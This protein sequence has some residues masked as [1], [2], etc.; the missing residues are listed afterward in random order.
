MRRLA[1]TGILR[2]VLI[3]ALAALA[4]A[5]GVFVAA[6]LLFPLNGIQVTGARMYPESEVSSLVS[7]RSSLLTLNTRMLEREI[8]A[9]PWVETAEVRKDWESSIVSVEV[10]ERRAVLYGEL[11]G[12]EVILSGD[13][14]ELPGLGGADLNRVELGRDQV[15]E[16][17]DAVRTF[18]ENGVRFVSVDGVGPGGVEATVA[19][20]PVIFSG[21]VEEKQALAL[22][23]VMERHPEAP[24]FDL[25]SPERVVVGASGGG[26]DETEG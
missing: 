24:V 13:G 9:N 22:E 21:E 17:L 11:E 16:I 3:S 15:P 8:E 25:R 2:A 18:E 7:D 5:A 1:A 12:R 4:T 26:D 6:Y 10:E 23:D 20:R 14:E 19:G